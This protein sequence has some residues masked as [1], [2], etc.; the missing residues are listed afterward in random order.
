VQLPEDDP[1]I[2]QQ[3]RQDL[4]DRLRMERMLLSRPGAQ[5]KGRYHILL[6]TGI[7]QN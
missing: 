7:I 1:I 2:V 6:A 4:V 5:L 3:S